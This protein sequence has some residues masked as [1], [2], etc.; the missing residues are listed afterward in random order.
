MM[1]ANIVFLVGSIICATAQNAQ[2]LIGGRATQG[3]GGGGILML[4]NIC[5]SDLFSI[6][7]RGKYFGIVGLTFATA[8]ALGPVVGRAFT[9]KLSWRWCF[10]V[11]LPTIGLGIL[12]L[13]FFLDIHTPTTPLIEGLKA[14]DWAGTILATGGTTMFLLGL[15]FGGVTFP[16][17][18]ATVICLISL[19]LLTLGVFFVAEA[20][21][22]VWPIIP[23]RIVAHRS[24][25]ASLLVIF[26]HGFAFA[27]GSYFLP[28]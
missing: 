27:A 24:M 5:I 12:G 18:S 19:G 9:E 21:V 13:F 22:A 23:M 7:N 17:N 20:R 10:Y 11:N 8:G 6:R 16:W 1:L 25:L 4:V 2:M 28:L 14:I 15:L 3:I 26:V